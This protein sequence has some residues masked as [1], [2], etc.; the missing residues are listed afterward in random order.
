MTESS[1]AGRRLEHFE[2]L[3]GVDDE[4][5]RQVGARVHIMDLAYAFGTADPALLDRLLGA[6][7]PGLAA[8]I[9]AG[10]QMM[11]SEE[12]RFPL[13]VQ[14]TTARSR[15]LEIARSMVDEPTQTARQEGESLMAVATGT[16]GV[17]IIGTGRISGAHARA[18]QSVDATRLV[19]ASEVDE[20]R[21]KQFAE[22]WGCEVVHG[23]PR[24]PRP[25][26]RADR[27]PHPA[28]LPAL[29][30]GRSRPPGPGSTSSSR[31]R[32]RT[33]SKSATR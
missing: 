22:R 5:L 17:A 25:G 19:A 31:S 23:L 28:P 29:P 13:D 8:D 26:R 7:R 10:V 27:G 12:H 21:G 20:A 14:I 30:G 4:M 18:A 2:D 32:W 24:P 33:R 9:R 3:A 16:Y 1:G 11:S 15:V 6:V